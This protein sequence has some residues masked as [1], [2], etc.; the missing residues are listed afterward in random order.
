MIDIYNSSGNKNK[1]QMILIKSA[2]IQIW[3][4]WDMINDYLP[5][6]LMEFKIIINLTIWQTA[7]ITVFLLLYG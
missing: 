7:L 2:N 3:I 6:F 5:C 4:F 1:V